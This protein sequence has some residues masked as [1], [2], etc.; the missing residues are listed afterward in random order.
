V[1][2]D[3]LV[4]LEARSGRIKRPSLEALSEGRR[5]A[6]AMQSRLH[7][8]LAGSSVAGL[9]AGLAAQG[10]DTILVA[11]SDLLELYQSEAYAEVLAAAARKTGAGHLF[12]AA[13]SLGRDLAARTAAKLDAGV[14]SDCTEVQVS[15]EGLRLKRPVYSGKA[16]A[17]VRFAA[18]PSIATLRPNAFPVLELAGRRPAVENLPVEIP[19]AGIRART[20]E[21]K[22]GSAGEL[23]VSEASIVV[24]GG[25]AMKGPENFRLIRELAA[26]LGGAVGASRAAVDAGWIGHQYQVGQT[27]KVVAPNLYIA[28]GISGAIQH[29]AGMSTSKVIVAI[30]KDPEAP[31]FKVADYGIVGDL[32]EILPKLTE[33]VRKLKGE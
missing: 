32:Y 12:L 14:A 3:F 1:S 27:G 23:D 8:V 20:V 22:T 2:K 9:A 31:I 33:E 5:A 25:R 4:F 30:N 24:S 19:P 13:T 7:A 17:T 29:L 21:V 28:C 6:D 26:A 10:P 16:I 18:L 15:A 11:E